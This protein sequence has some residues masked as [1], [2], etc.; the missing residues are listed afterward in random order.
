MKSVLKM[1][2]GSPS[3]DLTGTYLY[4]ELVIPAVGEFE[5]RATNR[6]EEEGEADVIEEFVK[7][8]NM[9]SLTIKA[10]NVPCHIDMEEIQTMCVDLDLSEDAMREVRTLIKEFRQEMKGVA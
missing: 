10:L 3:D 7:T 4:L 1:Y 2:V 9:A 8:L 5:L 6:L